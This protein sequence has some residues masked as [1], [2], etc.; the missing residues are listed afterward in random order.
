M[1]PRQGEQPIDQGLQAMSRTVPTVLPI[2]MASPAPLPPPADVDSSGMS[3]TGLLSPDPAVN[4]TA[5]L[6]EV[7]NENEHENFWKDLEESFLSPD[8]TAGQQNLATAL[9][10][11]GTIDIDN[12]MPRNGC[13]EMPPSAVSNTINSGTTNVPAPCL[14]SAR[15]H[16][17]ETAMVQV[18][19][20][21]MSTYGPATSLGPASSKGP[22]SNRNPEQEKEIEQ[23]QQLLDTANDN[24][25]RNYE[26]MTQKMERSATQIQRGCRKIPTSCWR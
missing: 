26:I 5:E 10:N 6:S 14:L 9:A 3:I 13:A 22:Y 21:L 23:L 11:Q 24:A 25:N 17:A 2:A 7:M 20:D 8:R 15:T 16:N 18:A 4:L 19:N 12:N 1:S